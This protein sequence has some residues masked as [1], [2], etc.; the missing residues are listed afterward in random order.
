MR[1]RTDREPIR[2]IAQ[3]A[4][5]AMEQLVLVDDA[6]RQRLIPV[7]VQRLAFIHDFG[8]RRVSARAGLPPSLLPLK[9]WWSRRR[10]LR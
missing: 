10:H 1:S 9:R 8:A 3:A 4:H 5:D 7:Y 2:S 6:L